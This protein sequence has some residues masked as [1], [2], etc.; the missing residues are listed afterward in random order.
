MKSI[1]SYITI[2]ALI[3][4]TFACESDFEPPH[5]I[6]N[7]GGFVRFEGELADINYTIDLADASSIF[8]ATIVAPGENVVSYDLSFT[9]VQP[10]KGELGPFPL[11]SVSSFP[12]DLTI[13]ASEVASAAGVDLADL[14]GGD[15]IDVLATVTN[16]DGL[17]FTQDNFNGDLVNPGQRGAMQYSVF[18]FC[19]WTQAEALAGTYLITRDDFV[20]TLDAERPIEVVAGPGENEITFID[21]FS[22]PEAYDITV[23][24][25]DPSTAAAVVAKQP[26][27]HCDNFGCG[28]GEGRVEGGGLFFSCS[29]FITLD[30]AHT[31]DAGSF[32]T[33]RLELLRQ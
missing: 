8:Q 11:K 9:L 6:T 17:S 26:A 2:L 24:V 16:S 13:S 30:L 19:P 23:A 14:G 7:K 27:W 22:H 4:L 21:L 32:G 18:F 10:G 3:A 28:F 31:V 5:E 12:S 25:P 15:R 29:G 20:T 33:F 1:S